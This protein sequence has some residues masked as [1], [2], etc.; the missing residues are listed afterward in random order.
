MNLLKGQ[1]W[2]IIIITSIVLL[3]ACK[4]E[5]KKKQVAVPVKLKGDTT[6]V[7][8]DLSLRILGFRVYK[9][10]TTKFKKLFTQPVTLSIIEKQGEEAPFYY[11]RF[12]SKPNHITLFYKPKEGFYIEDAEI[13]NADVTLNKKVSFDMNKADFLKVLKADSITVDTIRVS[14]EAYAVQSIF[15]FKKDKLKKIKVTQTVE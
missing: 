6:F 14:D 12:I 10:D 15:I 13:N 7:N 8:N 9:A 5:V 1:A 4:S 3:W 2:L 11:Y